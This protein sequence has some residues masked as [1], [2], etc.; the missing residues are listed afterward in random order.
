MGASRR[1][2]AS[3]KRHGRGW[4]KH[5]DR[6]TA[7]WSRRKASS[8]TYCRGPGVGTADAAPARGA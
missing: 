1:G 3:K 2:T 6:G 8:L 7:T 5:R 4:C